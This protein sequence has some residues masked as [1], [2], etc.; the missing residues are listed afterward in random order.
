MANDLYRLAPEIAHS[1]ARAWTLHNH[2]LDRLA[3][4]YIDH[5]MDALVTE[6]QMGPNELAYQLVYIVPDMQLGTARR[7]VGLKFGWADPDG[8]LVAISKL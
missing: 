3:L 4:P 1:L 2:A 8:S 6:R 5:L 7:L